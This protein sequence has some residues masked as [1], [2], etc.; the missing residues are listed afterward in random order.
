MAA[1][2][3]GYL[4]S[5]AGS[6]GGA[7]SK[8]GIEAFIKTA[9]V[10]DVETR[11]IITSTNTV[12]RELATKGAKE[13]RVLAAEGQ[14]SGKGRLGRQFHSPEGHGA[15]FSLLLRPGDMLQRTGGKAGDESLMTTAAAVAAARAIEEVFDVRVG[16][17]W[18]ND[19][20]LGERKICGILTEAIMDMENGSV[21]SAILGIGIN[22]TMPDEG[23]PAAIGSIAAP[24]AGR[25]HGIDDRRCRLIASTLDNFWVFYENLAKREFLDEYRSRSIVL[26]RDIYVVRGDEYKP[27][28]ALGIDDEC[29]LVVQYENGETAAIGTGEVS[30]RTTDKRQVKR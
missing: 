28:R 4:L 1:T 19:L 10:F 9:G 24:I 20:F 8:A 25:S 30:V 21:E 3:K 14:T 29:K 27:A 17:K 5:N 2:K 18:V 7:L 16:I 22:I 11:K 26:G 15:Y 13:G 6:G 23:Y 12:L